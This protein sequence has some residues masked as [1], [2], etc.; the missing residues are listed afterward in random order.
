MAF[1]E[2]APSGLVELGIVYP[3]GSIDGRAEAERSA[4]AMRDGLRAGAIQLRGR[5]MTLDEAASA[6]PAALLLTEAALP[7]GDRLAA[8]LAGRG[9]P[10]ISTNPSAVASDKAVMAVRAEPRVEIIVSRAAARVA[11]VA[12]SAAFR[13]MIQER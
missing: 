11:G 10:T 3:V 5:P 9:V 8:L 4:T 13:M 2:P 12:F 1:L 7:Q 6:P